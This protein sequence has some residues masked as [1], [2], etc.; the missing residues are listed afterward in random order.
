MVYSESAKIIEPQELKAIIEEEYT[1]P[2]IERLMFIEAK[3]KGTDATK[4]FPC[5]LEAWAEDEEDP[6]GL[7]FQICI[8][9]CGEGEFGLVRVVVHGKE[10][11][12]TKRMWDRAPTKG[13]REDHPF[14]QEVT[15]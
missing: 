10:F 11:G 3:A 15:Q 1:N 2:T 8:A 9:Q 12:Y 14:L 6:T 7:V 5:F 13:L 4:V